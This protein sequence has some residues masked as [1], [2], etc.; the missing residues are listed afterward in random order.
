MRPG[1]IALYEEAL[2]G[3]AASLTLRTADGR[4]LAL[5]VSRWCGRPDA[6]DEELLRHCLGAGPRRP[7][8]Q[9]SGAVDNAAGGGRAPGFPVQHGR[10]F[11]T[12]L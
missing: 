12:G 10:A 4:A 7:E 1:A 8:G 5:Q 11:L 3:Q 2:R 9:N 6:A